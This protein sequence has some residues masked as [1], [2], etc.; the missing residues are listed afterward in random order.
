MRKYLKYTALLSVVS[1]LLFI[2][3]FSANIGFAADTVLNELDQL[4]SDIDCS[5]IDS[6]S[7]GAQEQAKQ[8]CGDYELNDFIDLA[9]KVSQ[10]ILGVTG[11]LALIFFIYGGFIFLISGGSSE[12]VTKA[13]QIIIGAVIGIV[14][15]FT[16][17][18]IIGF[19]FQALGADTS[20][21]AWSTTDWFK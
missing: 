12:K 8:Y 20:G 7:G 9:V 4:P 14:L 3:V 1:Y 15:V 13:K 17:Y 11:S 18:M 10:I 19:V 6:Y 2:I 16:S 5:N 21:T